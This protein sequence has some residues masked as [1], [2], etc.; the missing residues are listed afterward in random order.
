MRFEGLTP[1]LA[2]THFTDVK[3][4]VLDFYFRRSA[5]FT[6]DGILYVKEIAKHGEI[7]KAEFDIFALRKTQGS[8][9]GLQG[10]T[11]TDPVERRS[12]QNIK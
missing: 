1:S 10:T 3:S 9:G 6:V 7:I 4:R 2:S 8:T 11:N 12:E 5:G